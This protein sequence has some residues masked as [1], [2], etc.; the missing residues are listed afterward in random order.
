MIISQVNHPRDRWVCTVAVRL[1]ENELNKSAP[2][3]LCL[4]YRHGGLPFK[5]SAPPPHT[6]THLIRTLIVL[7]KMGKLR[8]RFEQR[9]QKQME[10]GWR[11]RDKDTQKRQTDESRMR[12]DFSQKA[13]ERSVV[14]NLKRTD[15]Y[16]LV[17]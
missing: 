13:A 7:I 9:K 14:E 11:G 6:H 4:T 8:R 16:L 17:K 10:V 5:C 12:K 15:L 1:Y 3:A 2:D